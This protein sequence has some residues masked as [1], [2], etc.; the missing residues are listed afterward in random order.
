MIA[1][2]KAPG[3]NACAIVRDFAAAAGRLSAITADWRQGQF[4]AGD[5]SDANA[6]VEGL[7]VL[8][9]ELRQE[10]RQ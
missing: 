3:R 6:I 10:V 1:C 9:I 8:L 2:A 4:K 5:L 7:R